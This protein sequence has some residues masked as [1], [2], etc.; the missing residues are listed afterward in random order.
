LNP[1]V[2]APSGADV[3][4]EF[5]PQ[6]DGRFRIEGELGFATAGAALARSRRLFRDHAV[7]DL[8]LSGVRRAD[9]AGLALLLEWVN[10]ARNNAREIQF[11]HIP[12]QLMS[13]AQISEVDDMLHRAERWSQD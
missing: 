5:Q 12:A 1:G 4:V 11:H 2:R 8:D 7:I 13:I 10:W 6:G 9:S 3:D